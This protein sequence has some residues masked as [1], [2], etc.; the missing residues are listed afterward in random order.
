MWVECRRSTFDFV[1]SSVVRRYRINKKFRFADCVS[2][3]RHLSQSIVFHAML[4]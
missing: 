4:S 1:V 2:E 3:P